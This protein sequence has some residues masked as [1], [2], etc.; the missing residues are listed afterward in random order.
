L[1]ANDCGGYDADKGWA[2]DSSEAVAPVS[3]AILRPE[4]L[5]DGSQDN[6]SLSAFQWQT[7][8]AHGRQTGALAKE[9]S[10]L[11]VPAYA[12]LFELTGRWHDVGKVHPAFNNSIK[13]ENRPNRSDLAKAP[14]EAWLPVNLLY[15]MEDGRRRAGFRHELASVLALIEVLKRHNPD[16]P[17][18]LGP[19]RALLASAGMAPQSAPA[20]ATQPNPLEQEILDLD[21]E[22]FNLAAYLVC[23][24]HGK[25]RL[26]WHASPADQ[27]SGDER[28]RI[29]GLL[30]GDVLPPLPLAASD[31]TFHVMPQTTIDLS[32]AA[33]GLN[34][35]T[36]PSWTERVLALL[37]RHGPFTL[38]W[39]ESLLRAADQRSSRMPVRDELLEQEVTS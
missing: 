8:A 1:V 33:A 38:A 34:P 24:H 39:L 7:I 12:N 23:A 22:H 27:A 14:K 17:A 15:P 26:V 3:V 4:E 36:G 35:R 20:T 32:P 16:H 21:D 37:A 28:P 6:E 13:P 29:R 9:I 18:L 11:L 31:H 2:P 25:L 19:W 30:D 5:A 10:N